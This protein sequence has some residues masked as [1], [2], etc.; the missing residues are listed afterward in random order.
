MGRRANRTG[1]PDVA[2]T[3]KAQLR[4]HS[5]MSSQV[6]WGGGTTQVILGYLVY[7]GEEANIAICAM[8]DSKRLPCP[9]IY[10]VVV[11]V[12]FYLGLGSHRR[13]ECSDLYRGLCKN[14]R[15]TSNADPSSAFE[16]LDAQQ[17]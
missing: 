5:C 4:S 7:V 1:G 14:S 2:A 12:M 13:P 3:G 9:E 16:R 11:T 10:V 15:K 8:N 17:L 6:R